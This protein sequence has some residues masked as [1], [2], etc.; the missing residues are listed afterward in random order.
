MFKYNQDPY[1]T[2]QPILYTVASAIALGGNVIEFGTG[3]FSTHM[4][5][6]LAVGGKFNIFSYDNNDGWI[7]KFKRL[8]CEFHRITPIDTWDATIQQILND[9]V[10]YDLIFIDQAPWEARLESIK[11]LNNKCKYMI[12]HDCDYFQVHH[13]NNFNYDKYFKFYHIYKIAEN[14][15]LNLSPPTL[16]ASNEYGCNIRLILP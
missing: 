15:M 5:H 1:A 4:L 12:V 16:L 8:E 9:D 2:H 11:L 7:Q 6:E 13:D 14:I 10:H 3:K